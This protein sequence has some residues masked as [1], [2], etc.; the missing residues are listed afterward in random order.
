MAPEHAAGH[1]DD[2][3]PAADVYALGAILYECLTGRPPFKA[4][5]PLETLE[6]VRR[7]EPVPPSRL[8][9]DLPR[10]LQTICLKCLEKEPP[11]RYPSALA[12]AEDL[13]C[14][15][16]GEPIQA[17]PSSVWERL[18]KWARRKPAAAALV[19]VSGLSVLGLTTVVVA[20]NFRLQAEVQR[21]EAS[22]ARAVKHQERADAQYRDA[23]A[24]LRK[25]LDQLKQRGVADLP[26]LKELQQAQ[27]QD[28]L[29]FYQAVLQIVGA[30]RAQ[31][32]QAL[33]PTP[34][35]DLEAL[36]HQQPAAK[37]HL[38]AVQRMHPVE[39]IP[40]PAVGLHFL[41]VVCV[42]VHERLLLVRI[43]LEEKAA[44]LVKG[45]AQA[46]EELA[47]AALGKP[48]PEGLLDP[49][50][51]V[52]RRL[53]T[54]GSDLP[55]EVVELRRLQST[56]VAFVLQSTKGLQSAALVK[57]QPVADRAGTDP[58]EFGHLFE[59]QPSVQPEQGRETVVKAHVFLFAPQF[60]DLL[61]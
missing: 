22:E 44:D 29:A 12:M 11:H 42:V 33:P 3:G 18:P 43:G 37:Q 35:A 38:Q 19:A 15:L 8:Q 17:R 51:H 48:S 1:G 6:L 40:P 2:I 59:R 13:R 25:M 47:H 20:H 24:A 50:A 57:L 21:A 34:H 31:D 45:A 30:I 32:V 23:R 26:R 54:A 4:A 52:G 49:V 14:F 56:Q 9:P 39:E 5:T 53:E 7:Q 10:D 61:A 58:Q 60:V 28:A 36:A 16:A 41:L 27:L 46:M 55:F